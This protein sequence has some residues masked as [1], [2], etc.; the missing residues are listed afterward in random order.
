MVSAHGRV[1][2]R[3]GLASPSHR[4]AAGTRSGQPSTAAFGIE[5]GYVARVH[6]RRDHLDQLSKAQEVDAAWD[7]KKRANHAGTHTPN[8]AA[9][10]ANY[11]VFKLDAIRKVQCDSLVQDPTRAVGLVFGSHTQPGPIPNRGRHARFAVSTHL[12]PTRNIIGNKV[13]FHQ[14]RSQL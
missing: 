2:P 1:R 11:I 5:I 4:S 9:E 7:E 13:F 14:V 10:L 6:H 8:V 3:P 12:R